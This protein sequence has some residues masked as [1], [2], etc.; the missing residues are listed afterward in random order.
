MHAADV[1]AHLPQGRDRLA[2]TVQNHVGRIEIDEQ[3]VALDV[4]DELQQRVGRLLSGFQM[5]S[6]AVAA[7]M[8]AQ[9]PRH[10]QHLADTAGRPRRAARSPGAGPPRRTP[11][12]RAKSAISFISATRAARVS[13]GTSPTVRDDRGNVGVAFSLE[14]AE[15]GRHANA[16][17]RAA[18]PEL[19]GPRLGAARLRARASWMVG[20]PN[21]RATSSLHAQPGVD[22][23]E[24][25]DRPLFHG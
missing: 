22:A 3:I 15:D 23:G 17:P 13:G 5:Q 24:D 1:T 2:R 11:S 20:T 21:S 12:S 4:A 9:L 18:G 16:E 14:A 10:G 8:I 19:V 6:L 7:A 25:A